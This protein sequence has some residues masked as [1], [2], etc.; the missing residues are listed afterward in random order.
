MIVIFFCVGINLGQFCITHPQNAFSHAT[1]HVVTSVFP[2]WCHLCFFR[3]RHSSVL[4][5]HG[6][7]SPG[8]FFAFWL[9]TQQTDK[10]YSS[11]YI[12][13]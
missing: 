9:D 3:R 5:G 12:T 13:F 1:G 7:P 10:I 2:D 8:S 11:Q 6:G 4:A